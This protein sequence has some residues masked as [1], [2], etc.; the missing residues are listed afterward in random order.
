MLNE[1]LKEL[2]NK[3]NM[4]QKEFAKTIDISMVMRYRQNHLSNCS[5]LN[6]L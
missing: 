5:Q 2:R 6:R 1:R 4:T 3:R